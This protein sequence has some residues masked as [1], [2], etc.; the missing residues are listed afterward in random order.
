VM[1]FCSYLAIRVEDGVVLPFTAIIEHKINV[2]I[3]FICARV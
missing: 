2:E 3:E 1:P